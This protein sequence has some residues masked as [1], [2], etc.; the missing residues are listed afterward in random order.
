MT[1]SKSYISILVYIFFFILFLSKCNMRVN[2]KEAVV[3]KTTANIY[4][5]IG[6]TSSHV[7]LVLELPNTS[8][9]F[10]FNFRDDVIQRTYNGTHQIN[11]GCLI[12]NFHTGYKGSDVVLDPFIIEYEESNCD[13]LCVEIV[14]TAGFVHESYSYTI[15]NNENK[16]EIYIY[17]EESTLIIKKKLNYKTTKLQCVIP[18]K[19][20]N[21]FTLHTDSLKY[22]T[23]SNCLIKSG[24]TLCR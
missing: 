22:S 7:S 16:R 9:D 1:I 18:F 12:L 20:E 24:I 13:T 19:L 21:Y 10:T 2:K 23:D 5:G 3:A 8:N 6:F 4:Y 11:E 17:N 14:S 15:R